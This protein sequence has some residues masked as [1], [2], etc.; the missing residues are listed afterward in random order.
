MIV[1]WSS[2]QISSLIDITLS[3]CF[4]FDVRGGLVFWADT[5]GAPYIYSRL[6]KW[7]ELYGGFFKPSPYL[8]ERAKNGLPLV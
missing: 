3:D 4:V 6:N 7:A 2:L 5:V 8:E 1:F